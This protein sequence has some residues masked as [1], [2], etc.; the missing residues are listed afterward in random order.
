MLSFQPHGLATWAAMSAPGVLD[1]SRHYATRGG[2]SE[3][4]RKMQLMMDEAA[5]AREDEEEEGPEALQDR[6]GDR[7]EGGFAPLY[8]LPIEIVERILTYAILPSS[9]QVSQVRSKEELMHATIRLR[10]AYQLCLVSRQFD[11]LVRPQMYRCICVAHR[12]VRLLLRTLQASDTLAS[13]VRDLT[14]DS[15]IWTSDVNED[16]IVQLFIV[17]RSHCLRLRVGANE[18]PLLPYLFHGD[19]Q[20]ALSDERRTVAALQVLQ[21]CWRDEVDYDPRRIR[22]EEQWEEEMIAESGNA[23]TISARQTLVTLFEHAAQSALLASS[24]LPTA[25]RQLGGSSFV[26]LNHL[27]LDVYSQAQLDQLFLESGY[28]V[29]NVLP[30]LTFLR[31]EL[32]ITVLQCSTGSLHQG[33]GALARHW[34]SLR[35]MFQ[36]R[37]SNRLTDIMA[38]VTERNRQARQGHD[39]VSVKS[40]SWTRALDT[41]HVSDRYADRNVKSDSVCLAPCLVILLRS[42]LTRFALNVHRND[43]TLFGLLLNGSPVAEQNWSTR[44]TVAAH[45]LTQSMQR[46]LTTTSTAG[47]SDGTND[48]QLSESI[49]FPLAELQQQ[50]VQS[51]WDARWKEAERQRARHLPVTLGGGY[52]SRSDGESDGTSHAEHEVQVFLLLRWPAAQDAFFRYNAMV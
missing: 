3:M 14:L 37:T 17:V 43:T 28:F 27:T 15:H 47:K 2:M 5:T 31:V 21:I 26:N 25:A 11:V 16:V 22:A 30:L 20:H 9:V 1:P 33:R 10:N 19:P 18:S 4:E 23:S 32:P 40:E 6:P 51:Y 36:G 41:E 46:Q 12:K 35:F 38:D 50:G 39:H 44:A 48:G 7:S 13:Y 49:V 34:P 8:R 24:P 45:V 42:L 52:E 29:C